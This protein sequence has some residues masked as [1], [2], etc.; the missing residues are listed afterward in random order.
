MLLASTAKIAA[1]LEEDALASSAAE[2]A[3]RILQ[4]C[5]GRSSAVVAE[6]LQLRH[7]IG[8]QMAV[9]NDL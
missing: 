2:Q 7:D 9:C 8:A 6:M 1:L 3:V 4:T 5:N